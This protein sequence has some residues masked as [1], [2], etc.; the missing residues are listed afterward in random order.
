MSRAEHEG[1]RGRVL[2]HV[3]LRLAG[4]RRAASARGH[5]R[6]RT[7][8]GTRTVIK[9]RFTPLR[10]QGGR[11]SPGAVRKLLDAARYYATRP[12]VDG[13]RSYRAGFD[14]TSDEL[15]REDV[16]RF[17]EEN[18]R[19]PASRLAYRVV[20]SP[21]HDMDEREVRAW[22]RGVLERHGV[23]SFVAFA[24]AGEGAHTPNAHAHVLF[25]TEGRLE[26]ADLRALR[27]LGDDE[28]DRQR[29]VTRELDRARERE[30][31]RPRAPHV[32]LG[33]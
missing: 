15:G 26:R 7:G 12:D 23:T 5:G 8:S 33:G 1:A 11:V 14:A 30:E 24:H 10:G 27:A 31:A 29:G 4:A 22:T 9:A 19:D 28:V 20:M 17:I 32:E 6:A 2:Q 21:G 18:A 13:A 3:S 16:T 25:F